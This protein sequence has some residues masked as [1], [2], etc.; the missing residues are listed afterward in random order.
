MNGASQ[1]SSQLQA[2]GSPVGR[3][4][5]HESA[6]LHVAGRAQYVDDMALPAGTLHAAFALSSKAHAQITTLDLSAVLALP[7]VV[8]VA[9]PADVPGENNYGG[10]LQDDPIFTDTLVQY[11]GQPLFAV[12]ARDELTARRAAT[13][14]KIAYEELP[15]VLDIRSAVASDNHVLPSQRLLR[16]TPNAA[17][18]AA[19]RRLYGHVAIGGQDHFYLEGQVAVALPQEDGGM[20]IWSSTQHPTEVQHIVAHAIARHA[21]EVT[22]QCRRMGGGFGGKE[23][24]PGL[25]AAAAAILAVKTGKPVKLRLDRDVDMLATGKRHDFIA[26]Y[27]VG[28]E[29]DG[30]ITALKVMMASRCGYSADLSGPVNDRAL[31]HVDNAYFLE[32]VEIVSHRCKTNTVSNTAFRGFGGPQGMMVIEQIVDDIAR[33][34]GL[35]PLVVRR[36]NFYGIG[37]RDETP[38]GQRVDDNILD[39]ITDRLVDSSRYDERR[40]AIAAWNAGNPVI[41]RGLA[42]TPV[43]F[44]ISF[45]ATH[46]NQAGALLH[47]YND[48]TVLLNHGGTEMGQGLYTKVLQVVAHELSIPT[49]AIRVSAADT[50]KVPNT[51]ATAASSGSDLNG[52]AAQH[53]ARRI[54]RRLEKH[55]AGLYGVAPSD[56]R[57]DNGQVHIGELKTLTFQQLVQGAY[58]ARV[59]LSATGF[60][61]TPKIHWDRVN[62]RGRPFYYFAYGAAVVEVAIDTLTGETRLLQ[63]DILH[64]AGRSLNPAIDRGQ[65]EGGFLQG[66]GWLT[67]EEL[68]WNARGE[69]KTHAP[70]TYK[71]PTAYDWAERTTIDLLEHP[72]R[73]ASIHRSKAVG[74][75]PLMLGIAVWH[76]I[77]DA[78]AS[79][80]T[81]GQLITLPAPATPEAVLRAIGKLRGEAW[82]A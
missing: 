60:Y 11:A 78:V 40:T 72:N 63:V 1:P 41:K 8:D 27:D 82:A 75:P 52:K 12:A 30:R 28:F 58:F 36:R 35:D 77:R 61:R 46:F 34:L 76:A 73:E 81:P 66:A 68:W 7:G 26:D 70:S 16:G 38:Y 17:L 48:G 55:A 3:E 50:S 37:E 39:L 32:N 44:G 13:L 65:I 14:A 23:S 4:Q 29:A 56:V 67:S 19:P 15:A 31:C 18:D 64:D 59:P 47:V 79:C 22:V 69:L 21:H 43:K 49:S 62:L 6:H 10:I 74:E 9:L 51:S 5:R 80:A 20:L 54:R 53:A 33:T 45:N 42:L 71:I 25:I 2:E 57:F 24:Q